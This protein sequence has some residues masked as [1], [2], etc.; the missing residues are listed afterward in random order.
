MIQ[1]RGKNRSMNASIH[2]VAKRAGVSIS[3][4]SRVI[5]NSAGVKE[6]KVQA[7]KEALEY[8]D[9]QPSQ[10]GRGLVTGSSRLIGV[11][12]PLED[13]SMFENGYLLEC[14]RGI[15]NVIRESPYSLLLMSESINYEKNEK[16]RPKFIDYVSQ[17]RIDGLIALAVPSDGRVEGALSAVIE[18]GFPVGYIGK[19]FHE[20]G[21][22]VYASYEEYMM[23]GIERL[24]RHGHRKIAFFPLK[25][26]SSINQK[27]KS[28]AETKYV[29]L[30]VI[31]T[32]INSGIDVN[33]LADIIS[34]M[35]GEEH[36]TAMICEDI[37]HVMKIQN[38]L[39]T[40]GKQIGTDISMISV[41]H[42]KNQGNQILPKIDC[43]YVPA[44]EIGETIATE[45][46]NQLK[47]RENCEISKKFMPEYMERGSVKELEI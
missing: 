1:S 29:G 28:K 41:E 33:F 44:L 21:V 25:S 13:G 40:I 47:G 23:D 36:V 7:V 11:Y 45:L 24:Y 26:R 30:K 38:I 4:V 18:D 9:Y 19:R 42:V 35:V 2:D 46:L 6:S 20:K 3:T 27:I 5:N 10:F 32:D 43:Y 8:Y 39:H 15:D 14:L 16:T 22:N 31:I 17:K 34:Y 37:N 12:S